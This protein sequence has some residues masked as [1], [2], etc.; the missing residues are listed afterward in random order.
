MATRRKKNGITIVMHA[1]PPRKLGRPPGPSTDITRA[2]V[3]LPVG[4]ALFVSDM[5]RYPSAKTQA[6]RYG[7]KLGRKFRTEPCKGGGFGIWRMA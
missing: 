4:G 5:K 1:A 7:Q 3:D 6:S 2:L